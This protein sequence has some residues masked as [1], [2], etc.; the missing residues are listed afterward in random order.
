MVS[1]NRQSPGRLGCRMRQTRKLW[2]LQRGLS[3][4]T[5]HPTGASGQTPHG[6]TL[7]PPLPGLLTSCPCL[8]QFLGGTR[9]AL[10]S[11]SM[12]PCCLC[13]QLERLG[14]AIAWVSWDPALG[15]LCGGWS[16]G[17]R[18]HC[19]L[20]L[21]PCL[22]SRGLCPASRS[23]R[24]FKTRCLCDL[25]KRSQASR[26]ARSLGSPTLARVEALQL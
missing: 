25:R 24:S 21:P 8:P 5:A 1:R 12:N 15:M 10:D 3:V 20:A 26:A 23:T 17:G 18:G 13:P 16:P 4:E 14:R 6:L 2:G 19:G 7:C 11:Q 9:R 22:L